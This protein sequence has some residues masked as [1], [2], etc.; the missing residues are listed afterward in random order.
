MAN[1]RDRQRGRKARLSQLLA[2][3]RSVSNYVWVV[4]TKFDLAVSFRAY[5]TRSGTGTRTRKTSHA[6]LGKSKKM[7]SRD[8]FASR[9]CY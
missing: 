2:L 7:S 9:Y 5:R 6:V 8:P 3:G 1:G 4:N